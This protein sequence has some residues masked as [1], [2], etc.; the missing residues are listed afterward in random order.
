MESHFDSYTPRL[1]ATLYKVCMVIVRLLLAYFFLTAFLWKL[2]N[3]NFGCGGEFAFPVPAEQNYYDSN[4]SSGLCYWMGLESIYASQPRKVL[5][6]DMRPAGLPAITVNITPLA[7]INGFLLDNLFIPQ[8]R[9]FGWLVFLTEFWV[10][11]SML[12]GLFTRLGGLAAFGI[13]LQLY[14]GLANVPRPVEWEWTYGY[15]VMLAI[16][17]LGA[18]AGRTFGIDGI[19]RKKLSAPAERGNRLAK[20]ALLLT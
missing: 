12:L 4:G 6:A 11:L 1:D 18:A 19:L 13:S 14:I 17:M 8:I 2:P 15:L 9:V 3:R 16:A 5:V 7:K 10:F 20:F